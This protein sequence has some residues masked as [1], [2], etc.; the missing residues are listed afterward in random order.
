ML[1]E[2]A[3]VLRADPVG[4][5]EAAP[6]WQARWQHGRRGIKATLDAGPRGLLNEVL[7]RESGLAQPPAA[8]QP[9]LLAACLSFVDRPNRVLLATRSEPFQRE[10]LDYLVAAGHY[11][12]VALERSK[13][14]DQTLEKE[15]RLAALVQI[16]HL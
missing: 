3:G 15:E 2:I 8:N 9:A 14:F 12:G 6:Q 13:A 4:V 16:A 11:L 5:W 7:D 10:E 1:E